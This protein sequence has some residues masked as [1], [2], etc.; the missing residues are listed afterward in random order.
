MMTEAT[1]R[2]GAALVTG[3]VLAAG[4]ADNGVAE[5]A[6]GKD[7]GAMLQLQGFLSRA[8][9]QCGFREYSTELLQ[10]AR[11]CAQK[12]SKAQVK[13]ILA[14]GMQAFDRNEKDR[15]HEQLCRD[16]E[17]DF[18]GTIGGT[19]HPELDQ[20]ETTLRQQIGD[21][22]FREAVKTARTLETE[23]LRLVGANDPAY[24]SALKGLGWALLEAGH[25]ADAVDTTKKL[26][27]LE[28]RLHTT[29]TASLAEALNNLAEML[30]RQDRLQE[31][32]PLFRRAL[33]IHH[34]VSGPDNEWTAGAALNLAIV[35]SKR[36]KY[37][38]AEGLFKSALRVF[39]RPSVDGPKGQRTATTLF[40]MGV[41]AD[42]RGRT[43]EGRVL[44]E[45]AIAI[46]E[47]TLGPKHPDFARSLK[48]IGDLL[49]DARKYAEATL[50]YTRALEIAETTLGISHPVT[51]SL[52]DKVGSVTLLNSVFS[53]GPNGRRDEFLTQIRARLNC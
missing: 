35:L 2:V 13:S 5:P 34:K 17:R 44:F 7:C 43:D 42:A 41:L 12:L 15:G 40:N 9:F 26:V 16:V 50:Y 37:Q 20:L 49:F 47:K 6:G 32:E 8:Q 10:A 19:N 45:R 51:A 53:G 28:E 25:M 23:A 48:A 18:A 39:E 21:G 14:S 27:A 38:E 29:E 24:A 30:S 52:L 4:P 11:G 3:L 31:A 22:N 36:R 1:L 46:Q 33:K